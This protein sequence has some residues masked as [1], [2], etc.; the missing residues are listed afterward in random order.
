VP[1]RAQYTP[2]VEENPLPVKEMMLPGTTVARETD[3]RFIAVTRSIVM[4][5]DVKSCP[6][7]DTSTVVLPATLFTDTQER[8]SALVSW[9][10]VTTEPNLH[11]A[12]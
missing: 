7:R 2:R 8:V 12:V 5:D 11:Q 4:P 1:E 3:V 6:L 9:A 10:A